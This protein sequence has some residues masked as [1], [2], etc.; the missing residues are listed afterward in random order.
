MGFFG[1]LLGADEKEARINELKS[2]CSQYAHNQE[3]LKEQ[4]ML[5]YTN[6]KNYIITIM[7]IRELLKSIQNLP[8]WCN[9]DINESVNRTKDF[10]MAMDYEKE[11]LKFAQLTDSTGRTAAYIGAGTA[12]GAAIGTLGPTAAMSIA[13]VMGTASTGTAIGTLSGAAATNA[14]LA[15]LGG[16]TL[17][18]GGAGIAGGNLVLGMFGPIGAAI[19]GISVIG[20]VAFLRTKNRKQAEEASKYIS[21]IK[22]DNVNLELKLSHLSDIISRSNRTSKRLDQ[23]HNWLKEA[24][25]IDYSQWEDG[26]KHELEKLMNNISNMVQIINERI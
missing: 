16:G 13:T 17:A 15:W 25:P 9:Y 18:A 21:S 26:Q 22:H 2:E 20:G 14:A 7:D 19:A 4:A 3:R 8:E 12:T 11:P 6:R 1:S 23:S 24:T 5:L 10:R